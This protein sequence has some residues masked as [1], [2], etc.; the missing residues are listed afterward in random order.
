MNGWIESPAQIARRKA[1]ILAGT[2]KPQNR[3]VIPAMTRAEYDALPPIVKYF[4]SWERARKP[5]TI[6]KVQPPERV[7]RRKQ[8][9]P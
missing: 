2:R 4:L 5:L 6:K 9:K 1:R 8:A 7:T 3:R